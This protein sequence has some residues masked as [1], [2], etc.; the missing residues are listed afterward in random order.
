MKAE[1]TGCPQN[2]YSKDNKQ[3]DNSVQSSDIIY[4]TKVQEGHWCEERITATTDKFITATTD[5][6]IT[7]TTNKVITATIDKVI[8]ATTDKVIAAT[9]DKAIYDTTDKA[10]LEQNMDRK[11][12]MSRCFVTNA[13][14]VETD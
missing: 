6:V 3:G 4:R 14:H 9:T 11:R 12:L 2:L 8:T 1:Y 5:K 7:A 13:V 10:M